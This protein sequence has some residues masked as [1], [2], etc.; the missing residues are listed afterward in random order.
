MS[1]IHP[2]LAPQEQDIIVR[3]QRWSGF[4]AT[5]LELILRRA[6]VDHLIMIGVWSEACSETTVWDAI[7]RDF[8]ITIVKDACGTATDLMHMTAI[9]DLANWLYGGSIIKSSEL[10]K[11]LKGAPHHAWHFEKPASFAYSLENVRSLYE[12]I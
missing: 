4:F 5:N 10:A 7:W 1:D 12:S 11:A 6:G 8:R 2:L 3:K 9:L